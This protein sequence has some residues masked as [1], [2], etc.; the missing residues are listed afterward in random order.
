MGT[1]TTLE[2]IDIH[3]HLLT[4]ESRRYT[5]HE[6]HLIDALQLTDNL[7]IID[8]Q[9]LSDIDFQ[10]GIV[11]MNMRETYLDVI[12]LT[13]FCLNGHTV[14][15]SAPNAMTELTITVDIKFELSATIHI[16]DILA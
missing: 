12:A 9:F 5:T 2:T 6:D 4:L 7:L 13:L 8:G 16:H 14:R 11:G 15:C 10:I 1:V 3:R